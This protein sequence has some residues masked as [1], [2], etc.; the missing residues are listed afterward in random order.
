MEK[1][2]FVSGDGCIDLP[3]WKERMLDGKGR[4]SSASRAPRDLRDGLRTRKA[5]SRNHDF[6]WCFIIFVLTVASP[7]SSGLNEDN[8]H[9][10]QPRVQRDELPPPGQSTTHSNQQS[11]CTTAADRTVITRNSRSL[12][13]PPYAQNMHRTCL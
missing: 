10:H 4:G 1:G 8:S 13:Y 6:C 11:A 9:L 12:A 5:R 7:S 3:R 2:G